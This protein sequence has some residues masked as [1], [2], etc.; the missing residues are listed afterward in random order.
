M[1]ADKMAFSRLGG[2]LWVGFSIVTRM[3]SHT[4]GILGGKEILVIKDLKMGR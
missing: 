2:L 3:G 1:S 4:F